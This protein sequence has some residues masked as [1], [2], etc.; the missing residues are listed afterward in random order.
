[1]QDNLGYYD[2]HN[3]LY[4]SLSAEELFH[5]GKNNPAPRWQFFI[6]AYR[7]LYGKEINP[8][9]FF[10]D[11][12][13][14]EKFAELLYFNH[15]GPFPEFQAKFNLIIALSRFDAEEI[16]YVSSVVLKE[17]ARHGVIYAEY[18]IMFPP[19]TAK[20]V[21]FEKLLAACNGLSDAERELNQLGKEVKGRLALSLHRG[22]DFPSIYSWL[23]ELIANHEIA[24]KY[25]TGIDFCYIEE[26]FPPSDKKAFFENVLKDNR[27]K[28][29]EAL[30]ILYHVGESFQDKTPL[31]AA[32]W[33][34]ESAL[35]GAH[36]LG[37]CIALGVN[38]ITFENKT[39]SES[40][41][42][43]LDQ[44]DFEL[45]IFDEIQD[46]G[47]VLNYHKLQSERE[48]LLSLDLEDT[49]KVEY[50][51]EEISRLEVFQE[52]GMKCVKK[53]DAVIESCP[54]SNLY[55]GMID[56]LEN[57]PIKRFYKNGLHLTI[58]SDDPGIFNTDIAREYLLAKEAGLKE[59]DLKII[60]DSAKD[61]TSEKL[62][63][64]EK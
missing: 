61:Y 19:N 64:R 28:P 50:H 11:Y 3:H 41:K 13:D 22:G 12:K 53:T 32:R 55:I 23:K 40:V 37:H 9:T 4:G 33:V 36:R 54:T 45:K 21:Y 16:R 42:E 15:R 62:S 43:R 59:T 39:I 52:F 30:A 51:S 58:A 60:K 8:V 47:K 26:G 35:Y 56:S 14:K 5:I 57:H 1:M 49:V 2:L 7:E 18:R 48:K 6:P 44:V 46:I 63:G 34:I 20:D 25:I 31:S 24:K 17:H 10:E 29:D 38:P 27:S